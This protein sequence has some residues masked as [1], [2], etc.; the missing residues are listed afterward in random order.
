MTAPG[1]ATEHTTSRAAEGAGPAPFGRLLRHD[2]A[3][4]LRWWTY[5]LAAAVIALPIVLGVVKTQNGVF[6][7]HL[8]VYSQFM[9]SPVILV[10]PLVVALV[11]APRF[12]AEVGHRFITNT[13]TRV[14]IRRY[15]GAHLAAAATVAGVAAFLLAFLPF[16]VAF[17]VWPAVGDPRIDPS[18]YEMTAQE[19][20][21][22][23]LQRVSY[24]SLLAGG[25]FLYGVVYS[26]WVGLVGAGFAAL[27]LAAVVLIRNRALAFI[28]PFLLYLVQTLFAS[29]LGVPQLAF[30]FSAFPF[31]L[32]SQ[33]PLVA[34][35]GGLLLL[36]GV[37]VLWVV[38]LRRL[39]TLSRV[40]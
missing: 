17:Y 36:G 20:A 34:G 3:A 4:I 32:T 13:R 24:S 19:A 25:P 38:V 37:A 8:D 22:D 23:S 2:L 7:D 35:G 14:G 30:M 6:R 39:P 27:T 12:Y 1:G 15:V 26:L 40:T 10:F 16:V 29:L 5:P 28:A 33:A 18:V 31:G 21:T 11:A 9:V